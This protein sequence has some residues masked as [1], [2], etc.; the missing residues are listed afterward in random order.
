[1]QR[2]FRGLARMMAGLAIAH[3]SMCRVAAAAVGVT[4][5]A[6]FVE[7]RF[8]AEFEIDFGAAVTGDAGQSDERCSNA[9]NLVVALQARQIIVQFMWKIERQPA[10]L[11]LRDLAGLRHR[12]RRQ[13]GHRR[14]RQQR[15]PQ[16]A[17]HHGADRGR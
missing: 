5:A 7:A 9:G 3:R 11:D 1:M 2:D 16:A 6:K 8:D 12:E 4:I 17:P 15:E 13:R 14:H 10:A